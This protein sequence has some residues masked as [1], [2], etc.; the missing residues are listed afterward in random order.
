MS[1]RQHLVTIFLSQICYS[2]VHH[3]ILVAVGFDWREHGD[4]R[5]DEP[6]PNQNEQESEVY[7]TPVNLH[8]L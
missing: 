3:G 5:S 8:T 6:R 2:K 4:W 1:R 7:R